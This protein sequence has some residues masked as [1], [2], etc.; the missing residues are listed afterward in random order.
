MRS[1][2]FGILIFGVLWMF[3]PGQEIS[4]FNGSFETGDLS[5]WTASGQNRGF[6]EV[7]R[8]G[9]CFSSN[10]TRGIS[11]HGN[12]AVRIRSNHPGD[13]N[14][15]GILTSE[16]FTAGTAIR[17]LSLTENDDMAK[18]PGAVVLVVS[19]LNEAGKVLLA[20]ELKTTYVTLSPGNMMHGCYS[21]EMRDAQFREHLFETPKMA[22]L[23]VR[24]RFR[25][26]TAV[27]TKGFFTLIDDVQV[28]VPGV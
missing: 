9:S 16:P 11:F 5:G 25:Q 7:V 3:I 27:Q 26:H 21:G 12:F 6:A 17:F 1:F 28:A 23:T 13:T 2:F 20:R 15:A 24:I 14:S 10:N 19:I 18:H 4:L 8:S 22:G